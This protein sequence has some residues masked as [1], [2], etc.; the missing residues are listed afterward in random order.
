MLFPFKKDNKKCKYVR[1]LF[2]HPLHRMDLLTEHQFLFLFQLQ[3][4]P[5][6]VCGFLLNVTLPY[7]M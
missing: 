5:N 2:S 4:L 6:P 7:D 3:R 1:N